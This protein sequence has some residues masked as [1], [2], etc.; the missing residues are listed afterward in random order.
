PARATSLCFLL[1]PRSSPLSPPFPVAPPPQSH[2]FSYLVN[3]KCPNFAPT[4]RPHKTPRRAATAMRDHC[5]PAS[6]SL[7]DHQPPRLLI[8]GQEQRV[9][10]CVI[11]RQGIRRNAA[12]EGQPGGGVPQNIQPRPTPPASRRNHPRPPRRN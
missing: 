6:H 8:G 12:N 4:I 9:G 10:R 1:P 3:K 7:I 2:R 11:E 5:Q